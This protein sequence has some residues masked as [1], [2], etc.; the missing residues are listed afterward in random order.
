[1]TGPSTEAL[2]ERIAALERETRRTF[3]EAQREADAMFAQ[4][5]LSQLLTSGGPLSELASAV[6]VEVIRLCGAS[7][8]ALWLSRPGSGAWTKRQPN[9][10][11][12]S[13]SIPG[14]ARPRRAWSDLLEAEGEKRGK[15]GERPKYG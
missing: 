1:M 3:E 10:V 7:G 9:S 11:R 14:F 12:R 5:Q 2:L 6:L 8:G 15:R 13:G 4:Y